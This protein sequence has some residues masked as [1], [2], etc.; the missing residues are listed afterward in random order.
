MKFTP[1]VIIQQLSSRIITLLAHGIIRLLQNNAL[2]R[3]IGESGYETCRNHFDI[4]KTAKAF[5]RI[6]VQSLT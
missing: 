5:E 4:D 1:I 2:C 6:Y 3:K